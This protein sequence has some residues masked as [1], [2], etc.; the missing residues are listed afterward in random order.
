MSLWIDFALPLHAN[1]TLQVQMAPPAP[2]SGWSIRFDLVY[3]FGSPQPIISKYLASGYTTGQSGC[4]LVDGSIGIFQISQNPSEVSGLN[5]GN[6][7]YRAYRTDSGS[8]TDI[9]AGFRLCNPF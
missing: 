1:G 9:T 6:Y 4:T 5:D 3:R 2:I 8:V 7:A